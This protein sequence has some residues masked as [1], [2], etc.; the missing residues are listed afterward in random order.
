MDEKALQYAYELFQADGYADSLED[1]KNLINT[2][3]DA[4]NYSFELFQ[5]DGYQDSVDDFATLLGVKKKDNLDVVKPSLTGDTM[6]SDLET[7][8]LEQSRLE[9]E[10]RAEQDSI[11][12]TG[13]ILLD[14]QRELIEIQEQTIKFKKIYERVITIAFWIMWAL[15]TYTVIF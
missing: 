6:V 5:A 3:S 7:G 13:Q 2:N 1:F 8:G 14:K 12:T 15:F 9:E 4:F 11:N 10:F